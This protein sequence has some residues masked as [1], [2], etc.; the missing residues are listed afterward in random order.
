MPQP[1]FV[2]TD[3]MV[4]FL[5]G[6]QAAIALIEKN[7]A[8][9]LL[10]AIVVAELY[11]GVKGDEELAVLDRLIACVQVEPVTPGIARTGGLLRRDYKPT[12]GVGLADALLAASVQAEKGELK[13]LNVK[14]FPM[15]KGLEP[16]YVKHRA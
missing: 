5:R 10:S 11:A 8:R 15:F 4:D 16:A 7:H 12:H 3:V 9:I 1:V 13:T 6:E 2:D 14:H